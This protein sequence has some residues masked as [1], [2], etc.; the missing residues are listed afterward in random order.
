MTRRVAVFALAG[1]AAMLLGL[2]GAWGA[3]RITLSNTGLGIDYPGLRT[4]A[5]LA[6]A[7]TAAGLA[8]VLP[9]RS[10]GAA[11]LV[12]VTGFSILG[13]HR[14]V[15]RLEVGPAGL[16]V[17]D[18]RGSRRLAWRDV[19]QVEADAHA[20]LL[21]GRGGERV[22]ID[23]SGFTAEQRA[24]LERTVARRVREAQAPP[25]DAAPSGS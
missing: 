8:F 16:S 2:W 20:L 1:L 5:I 18:L 21:R 17:R 22:D 9:R 24:S 13:V 23:T 15:Y 10:L 11:A 7:G 12:A 25:K 6:A 19:T 14:L 3:P 4:L